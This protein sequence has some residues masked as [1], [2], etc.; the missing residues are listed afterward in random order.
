MCIITNN[1][2]KTQLLKIFKLVLIR[3]N[4][5]ITAWNQIIDYPDYLCI[6]YKCVIKMY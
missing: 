3:Y 2:W 4:F 5:L 1:K 6:M